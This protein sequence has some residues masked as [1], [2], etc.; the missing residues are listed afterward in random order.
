ML[1]G[2]FLSFLKELAWLVGEITFELSLRGPHTVCVVGSSILVAFFFLHFFFLKDLAWLVGEITLKP[3]CLFGDRTPCVLLT[4]RF[5][6]IF[7]I[8]FYFKEL[9][10]LIGGNYFKAKFVSTGTVHRVCVRC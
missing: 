5:L 6:G 9:A 3:S 8:F 2:R 1:T 4:R 7:F 10:W